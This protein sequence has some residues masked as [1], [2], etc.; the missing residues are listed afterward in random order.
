VSAVVIAALMAFL[1]GLSLNPANPKALMG[2]SAGPGSTSS[3]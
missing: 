1:L 3:A 2:T